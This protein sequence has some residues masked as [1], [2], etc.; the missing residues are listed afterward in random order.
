MTKSTYDPSSEINHNYLNALSVFSKEEIDTA[1][2]FAD[3]WYYSNNLNTIPADVKTKDDEYISI[4]YNWT[5]YQNKAIPQ[6]VFEKWKQ[7]GLFAYGIAIITGEIYRGENKGKFTTVFDFDQL[8][9]LE[10][11]CEYSGCSIK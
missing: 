1:N 7:M 10:K 9:A 11:Y 3:W 8:E 6:E 5:Q 4:L 2:Q